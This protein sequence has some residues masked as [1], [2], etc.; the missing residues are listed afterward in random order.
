MNPARIGLF[1]AL[2]GLLTS[3]AFTFGLYPRIAGSTGA[4]LDPDLYGTLAWGIYKINTFAYY[5]Q[6]VEPTITRGPLYSAMVAATLHLSNGWWPYCAQILQVLLFAGSAWLVFQLGHRWWNV[7]IG[8]LASLAYSLHPLTLWYSSRIW[9]E[10]LVVFLFTG[11]LW[12]MTSYIQQPGSGR[13]VIMGIFGGLACLAKSTFLPLT[14]L[15]PV[16]VWWT[17]P[18]RNWPALP[19]MLLLPLAIIA[20][21]SYRNY[22]LT[23]QFIPVHGHLGF[24]M[25]VGDVFIENL[26]NSP[27]GFPPSWEIAG[28]E[29]DQIIREHA[30]GKPDGWRT[31]IIVNERMGKT[32]RDTY[33]R[34]PGFLIKKLAL[35]AAFFWFWSENRTKTLAM[36]VLNFPLLA[37]FSFCLYRLVRREGWRREIVAALVL[38]VVFYA[39][40]LPVV[41]V[42]RYSVVVIP[43]MLTV[44]AGALFGASQTR[45]QVLQEAARA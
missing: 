29:A 11:L 36:A 18:R 17:N 41:S 22:A 7:R 26:P 9:I 20:P 6:S 33:L 4:V 16:L 40:H 5:P 30:G 31:E 14:L 42:V 45:N 12:A 39:G 38:A 43:V 1:L 13:A 37:L 23:G 8:V 15:A 27:W 3:S 32:S 19:V 2:F 10:T 35:D 24:N 28:R 21:W 25:R 44:I 34:D